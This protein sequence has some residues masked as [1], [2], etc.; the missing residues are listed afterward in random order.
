MD[1]NLGEGGFPGDPPRTELQRRIDRGEQPRAILEELYRDIQPRLYRFAYRK[2]GNV[3]DAYDVVQTVFV[4]MQENFAKMI[5]R[6]PVDPWVFTVAS[7]EVTN[8]YRKA[9]RDLPTDVEILE[10]D[11][12]AAELQVEP[13]E[14]EVE[15]WVGSARPILIYMRSLVAAGWIRQVDLDAYWQGTVEEVPQR[16]LAGPLGVTQGRVSQLRTELGQ[17]VRI[18]LYLGDILGVVRTRYRVAVICSHL[19]LFDLAVSLTQKDREL[20]RHAGAEVRLDALG[21]PVLLPKDAEVAIHALAYEP[22]PTLH[23]LHDAESA[24]ARA[25]PNP[26]PHC[27]ESP[28]AVHTASRT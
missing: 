6:E 18:A 22:E 9:K 10:R 5:T 4:K 2:L 27:I 25:I 16:I 15:T 24:Y 26:I 21:Q 12:A 23:D 7:R 20:L 19:Q 8:I 13:F 3:H 11:W 14:E 28:C 17:K 1:K